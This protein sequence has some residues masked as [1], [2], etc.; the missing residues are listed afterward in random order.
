MR[1]VYYT[2]TVELRCG[3]HVVASALKSPTGSA[4]P[5]AWEKG[6]VIGLEFPKHATHRYMW[7]G[8]G[9]G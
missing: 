6:Y 2:H 7:V 8:R 3:G 4:L 9:R 5:V 1:S